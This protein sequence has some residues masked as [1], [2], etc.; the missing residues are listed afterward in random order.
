MKSKRNLFLFIFLCAVIIGSFLYFSGKQPIP[1][2]V[3]VSP[4]NVPTTTIYVTSANSSKCHAIQVDSSDPQAFLPDPSCTPGEIDPS[5]TQDDIAMTICHSGYTQ[6]VR[7]LVS[8]TNTLKKQQIIDYGYTDT[9]MGDYEED[10]F[11]SLELGGS[12]KDPKN[13]WPE[14]HPSVNEKDR[15]ENYLHSEVCS[16][17]L[18]L[19]QAQQE[20]AKNWYEIYVQIR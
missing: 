5:V 3:S 2:N 9:R 18:S 12:P 20:I 1:Q 19:A 11:I 4:T 17:K 14:P 13:L 7:P 16:G 10:H 8:Y 15:V 6:T